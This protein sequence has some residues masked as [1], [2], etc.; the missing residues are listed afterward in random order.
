M[1]LFMILAEEK[2]PT[3]AAW[4]RALRNQGIPLQFTK[5][6][7]LRSARVLLP[8]ALHGHELGLRFSRDEY[9]QLESAY[10]R[11]AKLRV[12][13]PVVYTLGYAISLQES[14]AVFYSAA[15]LVA[16]F[17]AKAFEP[18]LGGFMTAQ[19]LLESA[20]GCCALAAP[21]ASYNVPRVLQ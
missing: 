17:G 20:E 13:Q 7:D 21:H 14:A 5:E 11:L 8:V 6:V 16:E 2:A 18:Q 15:A 4:Q 1:E 3:V 19:D 9:S 12:P 10:P